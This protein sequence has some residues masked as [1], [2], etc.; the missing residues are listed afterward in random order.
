MTAIIH[1]LRGKRKLSSELDSRWGDVSISYPNAGS[2]SQY[3]RISER[4]SP[5]SAQSSDHD[6]HAYGRKHSSGDCSDHHTAPSPDGPEQ[7]PRKGSVDSSLTIPTGY[8]DARVR[9]RSKTAPSS[10]EP[11][12]PQLARRPN[13]TLPQ[14]W[15]EERFNDSSAD[16]AECDSV[17]ALGCLKGREDAPDFSRPS[18]SPPLSVTSR[19]RRLSGHST[20]TD[21][22]SSSI[23][24]T[25]SS[26]RTS[27]SSSVPSASSEDPRLARH[28]PPHHEKKTPRRANPARLTTQQELVPSYDE[29]YG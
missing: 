22:T 18:K 19:M 9:S 2:W 16:E 14:A 13:I 6:G 4:V 12:P 26:K 27:F 29:L 5:T 17:S 25:A 10:P 23:P 15:E 8:Y 20:A 1:K 3:D 28:T 24:G 11:P 21:P 7:P